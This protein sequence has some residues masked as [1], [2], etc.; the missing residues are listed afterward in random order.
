M[1][2]CPLLQEPFV[3]LREVKTVA[4]LDDSRDTAFVDMNAYDQ[5]N[6]GSSAEYYGVYLRH[7]KNDVLAA[8]EDLVKHMRM[9]G[10]PECPTP[11]CL[12]EPHEPK[13]RTCRGCHL[14]AYCDPE[15]QLAHWRRGHRGECCAPAEEQAQFVGWLGGVV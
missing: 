13:R 12:R 2:V 3:Q 11:N 4:D 15:C 1:A 9:C 14:V 5:R 6:R 7:H 8:E 10:N